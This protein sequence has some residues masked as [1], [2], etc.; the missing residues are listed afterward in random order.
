M[1]LVD[2][3]IWVDFLRGESS[4]QRRILHDCI[5]NEEDIA[6]TGIILAEILQGIT[7]DRGFRAARNYLLEFPV[8]EPKGIATYIEAARIY[9]LCRSKGK[10]IRSTVDCINAAICIEND[11]PILHKDRDY[12]VIKECTGLKVLDVQ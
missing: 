11:L 8:Y 3:S 12:Y 9:R 1:I 5:E 2:T 10:T 4:L 7:E 6:I